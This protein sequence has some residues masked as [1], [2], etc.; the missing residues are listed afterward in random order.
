MEIAEESL[1]ELHDARHQPDIK[2][3]GSIGM[4]LDQFTNEV[5]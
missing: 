1:A 2:D 4:P 3:G 5:V